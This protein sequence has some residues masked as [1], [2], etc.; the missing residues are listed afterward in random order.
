MASRA[1]YP[2][3]IRL[4]TAPLSAFSRTMI[5]VPNVERAYTIPLVAVLYPLFRLK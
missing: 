2:I 4:K 3:K 1:I 5:Y